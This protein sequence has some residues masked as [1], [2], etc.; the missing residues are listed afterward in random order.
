MT[1]RLIRKRKIKHGDITRKEEK[2]QEPYL[3]NYIN[4]DRNKRK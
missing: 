1:R 2:V 4:V 3:R